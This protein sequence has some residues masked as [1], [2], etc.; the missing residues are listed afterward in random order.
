MR[1]KKLK[2]NTKMLINNILLKYSMCLS[3][4]S[5]DRILSSDRNAGELKFQPTSKFVVKYVKQR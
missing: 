2:S 4:M 3:A 5:N 1:C